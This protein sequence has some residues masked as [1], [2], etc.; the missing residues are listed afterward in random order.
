MKRWFC[1]LLLLPACC[2]LANEDWRTLDEKAM[3]ETLA[4]PQTLVLTNGQAL[5]GKAGGERDGRLVFRQVAGGGD[6]EYT[7]APDEVE[8]LTFADGQLKLQVFFLRAQGEHEKALA[9]LEALYEQRAPYLAWMEADERAYF[10]DLVEVARD[11]GKPYLSVGV[12]KRLAMYTQDAATL[13][14]LRDMILLGHYQLPLKADTQQL[15]ETWIAERDRYGGSALGWYIL[16]RLHYDAGDV[17]K[18]R[19][20]ALKPV[21]FSSQY[22]MDYLPHCY[23]IAILSAEALED[24]THANALKAEMEQRGLAWPA[25]EGLTRPEASP[26]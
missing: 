18:A 6:V 22:P 23:A 10:I 15:A 3:R 16:A 26:R 4:A 11:A 7:F 13:A 1:S 5:R 12:A 19:D 20:T 8:R 25:D 14:Q 24:D 21:V 17:A 9:I 2:L